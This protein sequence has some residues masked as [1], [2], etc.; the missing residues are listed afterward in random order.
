MDVFWENVE[1]SYFFLENGR[2][3]TKYG[4]KSIVFLRKQTF[5]GQNMDMKAVNCMW[6]I[7]K[8][9]KKGHPV[10]FLAKNVEELCWQNWCFLTKYRHGSRGFL[11]KILKWEHCVLMKIDVFLTIWSCEECALYRMNVFLTNMRM[12]VVISS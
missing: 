6:K 11:M 10:D 9:R 5:F 7:S 4:N 1:M 2:F 8:I 12:T 3:L